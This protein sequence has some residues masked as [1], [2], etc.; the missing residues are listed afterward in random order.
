MR[1]LQMCLMTRIIP[2]GQIFGVHLVPITLIPVHTELICQSMYIQG[3]LKMNNKHRVLIIAI[4]VI[5]LLS[6]CSDS[7]EESAVTEAAEIHYFNSIREFEDHERQDANGIIEYYTPGALNKEWTL[8]GI[9]ERQGSYVSFH[10]RR[11][12]EKEIPSYLP[13]LERQQLQ[14]LY[15]V[16]YLYYSEPEPGLAQFISNGYRETA[17]DGRSFYLNKAYYIPSVYGDTEH[18]TMLTGYEI[19]F[20]CDG[21][22]LYMHLPPDDY[23]ENMV[24]YLDLVK[25]PIKNSN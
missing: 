1:L 16:Q 12:T 8:S 22:L 19:T 11:V 9:S 21:K 25:T 2:P 6:A 15:L 3:D 10:Y 7:Q 24:H 20:I 14:E 5:L 13:D 4:I 23:L 17:A 18:K